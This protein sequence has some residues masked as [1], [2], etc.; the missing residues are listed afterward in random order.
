MIG[1]GV[2][3]RFLQNRP[4]Y[5]LLAVSG[6][7]GKVRMNAQPTVCVTKLN[8]CNADIAAIQGF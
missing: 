4:T 6:A 2:S 8:D 3:L 5:G 1:C 7:C